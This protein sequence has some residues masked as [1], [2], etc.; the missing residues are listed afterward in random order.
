MS[1]EKK[2]AN[3][4]HTHQALDNLK[5]YCVRRE[6]ERERVFAQVQWGRGVDMTCGQLGNHRTRD[7]QGDSA[8]MTAEDLVIMKV[9]V[10][11]V[12]LTL[13]VGGTTA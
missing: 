11:E 5:R 12:K 4:K 13:E 8:V 7:P 2:R 10:V 1:F 9:M 6:K 3:N